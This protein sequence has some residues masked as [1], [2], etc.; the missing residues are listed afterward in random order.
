MPDTR[1]YTGLPYIEK[2]VA[3]GNFGP[4]G[5]LPIKNVVLHT[6]QGTLNGTL[7]WFNN[8][9]SSVSSNYV[10]DTNGQIYAMLEEYY[11]PYTNGNYQSNQQ[12]ITI[13]VIDNGNPNGPRSDEMYKG[14]VALVKDVCQYYGLPIDRNTIKGH[15][16]VSNSHPQCPGNLDLDRVAREAAGGSGGGGAD[17]EKLKQVHDIVWEV[18]HDGKPSVWTKIARVKEVVPK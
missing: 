18:T 1:K 15:R 13:E 11:V 12:S 6:A 10:I 7:A 5:R 2:P 17:S 9:A 16:E 3:N 14:L 8:P 4:T